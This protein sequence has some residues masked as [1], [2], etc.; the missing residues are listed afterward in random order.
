M[1][2][3]VG[4]GISIHALGYFS[5]KQADD[6]DEAGA[7]FRPLWL[8]LWA[9]LNAL[10]LSADIFNIYVTLE[11]VGIAAVAL[12]TISG[13]R[14]ALTAGM[15]YLLV[16]LLGSLAYLMGTAILYGAYS[17][18]DISALGRLVAPGPASWTAIAL[19]T[20]GLLA[21]TALFPLH[22]WLPPAHA[23]APTPVSA[24]LSGLVVKASFYLVLRLWFQAF[25]AALTPGAGTFLGIL[26]AAAVLWGSVLSLRQVRI[27][28]LVAYSTVAQLG[29][30]FLM[31]PAAMTSPSPDRGVAIDWTSPALSGGIYHALS[32]AAAK[33]AM[34]MAA[35]L[36]YHAVG[37]DRIAELAGVARALPISV[38]TFVLAGLALM[39][40]PPSGAYVAK[41]LLLDAAAGTGQW[42]WELVMQAGGLLTASYVVLVLAHALRPADAPIK[43]HA[44]VS[45][46]AEVAALALALCSL[47]LGFAAVG[48]GIP[49]ALSSAF[50]PGELWSAAL[51]ILG[52]AALAA[53]LARELPTGSVGRGVAAIGRPVRRATVAVGAAFVCADG[54]LRQWPVAALALVALAIAFGA[55]L[56]S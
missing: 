26:G 42:W 12:V 56:G 1:T 48:A 28:M 22:F 19:M 15:R 29:Y 53:G 10:F 16:A 6:G 23:N 49:D 34:F 35:G 46:L 18:L 50:A 5:G 47:L 17:T 40:L 7:F 38:L 13:G 54:L 44:P 52:G 3:V 43:L 9:A 27:K 39:G 2:A 30:L 45:R 55:A 41:K 51:L 37:H 25:A 4:S 14:D 8:F 33:A 21:K 24:A 31:F 32:H 11:L 36:I 20:A